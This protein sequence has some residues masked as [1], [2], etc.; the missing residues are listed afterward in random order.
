MPLILVQLRLCA[1]SVAAVQPV[2]KFILIPFN[3]LTG[4]P[5]T[6]LS[7]DGDSKFACFTGMPV[8]LLTSELQ[9]LDP[10]LAYIYAICHRIVTSKKIDEKD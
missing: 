3:V 8:K 4:L 1:A 9:I 7:I 2:A 6:Q 10:P 5:I